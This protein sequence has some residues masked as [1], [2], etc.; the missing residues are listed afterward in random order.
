MSIERNGLRYELMKPNNRLK[1]HL[2]REKNRIFKDEQETV[3]CKDT[4]IAFVLARVAE[5]YDNIEEHANRK[6]IRRYNT[7]FKKEVKTAKNAV[8]AMRKAALEEVLK[9]DQETYTQEL[10]KLGLAFYVQRM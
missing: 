3:S 6:V 4:K 10:A 8:V 1:M 5:W 2:K 7:E 9:E